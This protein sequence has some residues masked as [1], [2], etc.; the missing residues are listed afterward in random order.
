VLGFTD[1]MDELLCVA[2]IVV[3]KPGGLTTSEILARGAALVIVNPIPGQ[4]S[5]NSDFLLENGAALKASS[6]ATLAYKLSTLLVNPQRLADIKANAARLGRPRAAYDVA[7]HAIEFAD[8]FRA[9]NRSATPAA[10]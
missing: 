1:Q 4:E 3:S 6:T 9:T 2:D 7:Q 8:R 5:R 10:F